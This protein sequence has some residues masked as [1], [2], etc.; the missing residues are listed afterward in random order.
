MGWRTEISHPVEPVSDEIPAWL[1]E[2]GRT[3]TAGTVEPVIEEPTAIEPAW[4]EVEEPA[5]IEGDTQPRHIP[6]AVAVPVIE[7]ISE[8]DADLGPLEEP[9]IGEPEAVI[10][11]VEPVEAGLSDEEE[12]FAWLESLAVRQG[13]DEA[14]MYSEEQ[15]PDEPPDWVKQ[16]ALEAEA[17]DVTPAPQAE[18]ETIAP[19]KDQVEEGEPSM[20]GWLLGAAAA[21]V[22]AVAVT[23]GES[24]DKA[25]E[26]EEPA[27]PGVIEEVA[28]EAPAEVPGDRQ[29]IEPVEGAKITASDAEMDAAFAWLESL[30]VRQ[31]AE[32]A[33]MY[34]EEERSEEPPDWVQKAAVAAAGAE[35]AA[36]M[37]EEITTQEVEGE[38]RLPDG[39]SVES[40]AQLPPE[41]LQAEKFPTE[42]PFTPIS[43]I[44]ETPG[45]ALL[46]EE[47]VLATEIAP[48]EAEKETI[49]EL[50][51]WL[52][53]LAEEP[54]ELAGEAS[55]LLPEADVVRLD[56]NQSLTG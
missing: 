51:P 29:G 49:P 6:A 48:I 28:V 18:L 10:S 35:V 30:A 44:V 3:D 9:E 39:I 23:A 25:H 19:E 8:P 22:A 14:L 20:P 11:A 26:V 42:E 12:A 24:A 36:E 47:P 31:G 17:S 45:E 56:I 46:P 41:A 50:P 55:W 15:R 38:A 37:R 52:A 32:E 16:S 53:D 13:A 33:L 1:E 2:T 7:T 54:D 40:E 5:I 4:L 21:G 27:Y 43:V 34:T